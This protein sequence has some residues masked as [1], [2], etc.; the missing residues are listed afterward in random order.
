MASKQ[1]V[2]NRLKDL[3]A[4]RQKKSH[5]VVNLEVV[6]DWLREIERAK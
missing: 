5:T 6:K 2:I 1:E 4:D 3:I